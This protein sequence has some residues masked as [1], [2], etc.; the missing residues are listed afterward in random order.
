MSSFEFG[1]LETPR[2]SASGSSTPSECGPSGMMGVGAE[3]ATIAIEHGTEASWGEGAVFDADV[4]PRQ[5]LTQ[6]VSV[7]I[8]SPYVEH[9]KAEPVLSRQKQAQVGWSYRQILEIVA[10]PPPDA[11]HLCTRG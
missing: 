2:Y 6:P 10:F 8:F 5:E 9:P 1:G 11:P 7:P 4:V 3:Q